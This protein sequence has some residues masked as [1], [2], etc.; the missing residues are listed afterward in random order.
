MRVLDFD[1]RGQDLLVTED[2]ADFTPVFKRGHGIRLYLGDG[3]GGFRLALFHRL[4]GAY[5]AVA[6]DFDGDGDRTSPRS[7]GSRTTRGDRPGRQA[8]STSRTAARPDSGPPGFPVSSA[9]SVS[10]SSTRAT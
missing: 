2:F 4:D 8:S 6:E 5:G 7:R 9:S 3:R 10:R 1:R